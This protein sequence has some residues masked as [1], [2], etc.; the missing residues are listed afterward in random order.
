MAILNLSCRLFDPI[1]ITTSTQIDRFIIDTWHDTGLMR[2]SLFNSLSGVESDSTGRVQLSSGMFIECPRVKVGVQIG[3][4]RALP[5][6]FYVVDDGAAPLLFGS[7]FLT[8]LFNIQSRP[9]A[10][11]SSPG[12]IS[13]EPPG[14]Y[15]P[16]S[17]GIRLI[18]DGETVDSLQLERFLKSVRSIHNIG[19]LSHSHMHQHDDWPR[20]GER[21]KRQAVRDTIE[22]DR[23]LYGE[24]TLHIS[25]VD[26]GS[27][28]IS[29]KSGAKSALSWL[30]QVFEKSTD[31][32]LRATMAIAEEAEA[33]AVSAE[34][35]AAIKKLTREE[36]ARA[37]AWEHRRNTAENIRETREEWRESILGEI[38][39]QEAIASRIQDPAV[40]EEAQRQIDQAIM[41]LVHSGF[42]PIIE[43]LPQIPAE[44]RDSL[45]TRRGRLRNERDDDNPNATNA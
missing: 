43:N 37:K 40:R 32:R 12:S 22:N 39:F 11:G 2:R 14:K 38:D 35:E 30:S 36:I 42:M 45:P 16:S 9:P 20:G 27:I 3:S 1:N 33:N 13:I 44:E 24:N 18:P 8:E 31:A 19:V 29:L 23:S 25:W 21:A 5:V 26:N 34:E 17:V 4:I 28:W 41:D 15:D 7:E 10:G 6:S